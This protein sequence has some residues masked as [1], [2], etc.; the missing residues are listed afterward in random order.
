MQTYSTK[1]LSYALGPFAVAQADGSEYTGR[2]NGQYMLEHGT[3]YNDNL[4]Q[5][6]LRRLQALR[7]ANS[8]DIL[9]FE[10]IPLLSEV[11]A[12]L[13]AVA[14]YRQSSGSAAPLHI[15]LVFPDGSLP[16][17]KIAS[18]GR[19]DMDD[20]IEAVFGDHGAEVAAIGIN[21]T[22]PH[23]LTSLVHA[24]DFGLR[25]VNL[26]RKPKLVS[27]ALIA[28]TSNQTPR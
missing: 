6:H 9:L 8:V 5:F 3:T 18:E 7:S 10:T 23:Y 4:K 2:Y 20:V 28:I 15:S 22:K 12:I 14:E 21:C 11:R 13:H 27:V 25:K 1:L 26:N 24:F 17:S 16:G 19:S